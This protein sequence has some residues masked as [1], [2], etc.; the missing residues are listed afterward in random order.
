MNPSRQAIVDALDT[1]T[2]VVGH[3]VIPDAPTTG[4]GWPVWE[5]GAFRGGKLANTIAHTYSAFVVVPAG[6]TY[7]TTDAADTLIDE[8]M[9]ALH[10]IGGV[11]VAEPVLIPVDPTSTVPAIRVRVTPDP[12]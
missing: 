8:L 9:H 12:C 7:D 1:V 4:D 10:K 3:Y 6:L 11:D 5:S 2:G